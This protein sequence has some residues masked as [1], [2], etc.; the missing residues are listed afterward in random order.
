[1]NEWILHLPGGDGSVWI[2]AFYPY[3]KK[4]NSIK[5]KTNTNIYKVCDTSNYSKGAILFK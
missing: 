4:H 3:L 2:I 1:M 5:I